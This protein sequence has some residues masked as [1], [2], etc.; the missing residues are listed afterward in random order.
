MNQQRGESE[1]ES[2]FPINPEQFKKQIQNRIE[3]FNW[4]RNSNAKRAARVT[5]WSAILG[6]LGTVAIGLSGMDLG[7]WKQLLNG[8]AL[9]LTA[10]V[11]ALQAW[12]GFFGHRQSSVFYSDG[13]TRLWE[14]GRDLE[15]VELISAPDVQGHAL[16]T[17]YARFQNTL[18]ELHE[19]WKRQQIEASK[20]AKES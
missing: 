2:D 6:A 20:G 13:Y 1:Y 3:M 19:Q 16:R 12:S 9:A 14:I 10:S 18:R 17:L 8:T 11:T 15:H 5:T 4:N 7:V